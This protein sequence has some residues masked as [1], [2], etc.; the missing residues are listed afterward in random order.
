MLYLSNLS[1]TPALASTKQYSGKV[2]SING[3]LIT[4][5]IPQSAIGDL[6]HIERRAQAPLPAQVVAFAG[7]LISLAPFDNTHGITPG[8]AVLNSNN[9]PQISLSEELLGSALDPLGNLIQRFTTPGMQSTETQC[10]IN[11]S[12]PTP[13]SRAPIS[14]QLITG[15]KTI[16]GLCSIGYG[17]RVGL[18][19]EAGLGKST[20]LGMLARNAEVDVCVVALVG[21]RGREVREFVEE[22]LCPETLKRSVLVIATSDESSIRRKLAAMTATTIAEYFRSQGKRV[23]LLVDSLTRMARAIREVTLA[24]G[25]LPVRQGYTSSVYTELP[26]LLERAGTD[27]QG[28]IT[29]IYTVLTTAGEDT[30]P[31]SDEIKS[32]LDGHIVLNK[33]LALQGIRPAIDLTLSVSRLLPKLHDSNYLKIVNIVVKILNRLKKDRD[34]LIFGGEPDSELKA[35]LAVEQELLELV[36]QTPLQVEKLKTL[37]SKLAQLAETFEGFVMD[38]AIT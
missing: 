36:T 24:A 3:P 38:T 32:L 6:C 10:A 25:E 35:C 14:K 21:E 33:D 11:A 16:D 37:Q 15:V 9:A 17:Q 2:V 7:D 22:S 29:A 5:R 8:A 20:L 28:S 30:D 13:L 26:A 19:S 34:L 18:F 31:L 1:E 23:L 4:A 27:A 12:A